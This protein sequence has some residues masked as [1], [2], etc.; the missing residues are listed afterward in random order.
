M[1]LFTAIA[2][3]VAG[4]AGWIGSLGA[5][6]SFVL[7]AA[8]G[9]GLNLIASAIAGK[10]KDPTFSINSTM[11]GGGDVPRSFIIG[12][13]STAGSFVWGNTWGQD[14]DTPNAFLTQVIAIS[15][16]PVSGLVEL[17]VNGELCTIGGT[18]HASGRGYP[19]TEYNKDG[20]D[21]L[22][23]KFYDGNQSTFDSFLTVYA[24]NSARQWSEEA[25][26]NGVAYAIL[27]ARVTKNLFSGIPSF[28]FVVDGIPLYDP[29]K[30]DTVGGSGD[31][32]WSDSSTWGGDGDLLPAVQAYN[33]LRGIYWNDE[34][35]YGLQNPSAAKLP[36]ADWIT[37]IAKCR[38][39]ITG[40]D[41][42]EPTYR[43]GGEISLDAP[44]GNALDAVLTT[45]AGR[46]SELGGYYR[47]FVGAPDSATINITDDDILSTYEQSFTPFYGLADSINGIIANYPSP[48]DGWVVK[49]A[50][51]L[52]RTDLEAKHGNRRLMADIDLNFVPYPEQVQRLILSALLEGQRARRH[53][54]VL[55]PKY[56]AY[57]VPG[58][59]ISWTSDANGYDTKLF[60]I[61]GAVDYD[62]L[63]VM[64]DITE[65]DPD[66]YDWDTEGDYSPPVDGATGPIRPEPVPVVDWFAE[67]WTVTGSG[68]TQRPGI[69][70]S[71]DY[72]QSG[73][74]GI[75][76]QVRIK[77][78]AEVVHTGNTQ[79][80]DAG[81]IIISNNLFSNT[82]YE[83]RGRYI[84][85]EAQD[86]VWSD[87]FEVTTPDIQF[88]DV[89]FT[90]AT[91]SDDLK[92]QL[93]DIRTFGNQL[94]SRLESLAASAVELAGKTS[95]QMTIS[96]KQ[97]DA[98]AVVLQ[99]FTVEIS[100]LGDEVS[101]FADA[102]TALEATVGDQTAGVYWRMFASAGVGDV[103][104][105]FSVEARA[106]VGDAFETAGLIIQTGYVGGDP[107]EPFS[108]VVVY[109]NQF[110]VADSGGTAVA[111]FDATGAYIENA[112]IKD[113]T[114]DNITAA[115]LDAAEILQDGTL[116]TDLFAFESVTE[117]EPVTY[118]Y[119][120]GV[121]SGVYN[122]DEGT[123]THHGT[124]IVSNP[125][126]TPFIEF[127]SVTVFGTITGTG[128]VD[129]FATVKRNGS[130][131]NV[132]DGD[133][134][135]N[136]ARSTT[137]TTNSA[138]PNTNF[139]NLGETT[140]RYDIWTWNELLVGG[141]S[142]GRITTTVNCG[143]LFWKV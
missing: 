86:A 10:P 91:A 45:C 23:I 51:P 20:A 50:P 135:A 72:A 24:S 35:F 117:Y 96:R 134:L 53:T 29:S 110:L 94:S 21:N 12:R 102:I 113:L 46:I 30:D 115:K 39:T 83:A 119:D 80:F 63:D 84:P 116:I 78:T 66:D 28:K 138:Q 141:S 129:L 37:Q 25:I 38:A 71:W 123:Y 136:A 48:A 106:D 16:L 124:V 65:V 60:R 43:S 125:A 40:A 56:W 82:V 142:T 36:V 69:K 7:K 120:S 130:A 15:D 133:I 58:E 32:R 59:V 126:A 3:I 74:V 114:A 81:A 61:D 87:W 93:T 5:I 54:I 33:L 31:H 109:G 122:Y 90:L 97:G 4:V 131:S 19:V 104:S 9:I 105:Q 42:P 118:S 108:R 64:V 92:D 18:P 88:N 132:A 107:G 140:V 143:V 77:A 41:G 34:W 98:Y 52:Y 13:Y 99:E 112:F 89:A 14:G 44:V 17:W 67:P 70:L 57:A 8:V 95:E 55:P 1:P 75:E 101:A 100:N 127:A 79:V 85:L 49:T 68:G 139:R 6:G 62:N 128:S 103:V 26:G 137:G 121:R 27:T 73:I 11:Q 47:I 111:L 2:G 76:F 22:W